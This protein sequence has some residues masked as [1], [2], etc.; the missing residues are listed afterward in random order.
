MVISWSLTRLAY[1]VSNREEHPSVQPSGISNMLSS[2][3]REKKT[4]AISLSTRATRNRGI[5]ARLQFNPPVLG[6]NVSEWW[7][8]G[9]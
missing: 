7:D 2:D 3:Y 5:A 4:F 8:L 1:P 6:V 9:G